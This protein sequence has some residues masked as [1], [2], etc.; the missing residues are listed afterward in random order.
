MGSQTGGEL[1]EK[2]I[3]NRSWVA[4]GAPETPQ[5]AQLPPRIEKSWQHPLNTNAEDDGDDGCDNDVGDNDDG[6]GDD[7][8][9]CEWYQMNVAVWYCKHIYINWFQQ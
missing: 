5:G 4:K 7:D 8:D 2:S 3:K 9:D 1:R 6:A